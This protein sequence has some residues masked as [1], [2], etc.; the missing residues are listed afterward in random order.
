MHLL[1]GILA[2]LHFTVADQH[3]QNDFSTQYGMNTI[4][5]KKAFCDE[6]GYIDQFQWFNSSAFNEAEKT[7]P[8]IKNLVLQRQSDWNRD[9]LNFGEN[10]PF[11]ECSRNYTELKSTV[12][13]ATRSEANLAATVDNFCLWAMILYRNSGLQLRVDA[14]SIKMWHD[15]FKGQLSLLTES[16]KE[17]IKR[18]GYVSRLYWGSL[19]GEQES[20]ATD[21]DYTKVRGHAQ[22]KDPFGAVVQTDYDDRTA[23]LFNVYCEEVQLFEDFQ[24]FNKTTRR[25][26]EDLHRYICTRNP[27]CAYH[28]YFPNPQ[29]WE[30]F[31]KMQTN[32]VITANP[33]TVW[34][35]KTNDFCRLALNS[36]KNGQLLQHDKEAQTLHEEFK[37]ASDLTNSDMAQINKCGKPFSLSVEPMKSPNRPAEVPEES[38]SHPQK[39]PEESGSYPQKFPEES[40][41][42]PQKFPKESGSYPQEFPQES[43]SHPQKFPEESSSHPPEFPQES[44]SHPH[45]FP[46]RSDST[47]NNEEMTTTSEVKSDIHQRFFGTTPNYNS[48][49]ATTNATSNTTSNTT[50]PFDLN[51][52]LTYWD[53]SNPVIIA[54]CVAVGCLFHT[55]VVLAIA[56]CVCSKKLKERE[57]RE[58]E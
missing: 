8:S 24:W 39:F 10:V 44:G 51:T 52:F 45:E 13:V 19:T 15:Y 56:L 2:L 7:L 32:A 48:T 18:C 40:G 54:L 23:R 5:L 11:D 14:N 53:F 38:G 20:S 41:S 4:Q 57:E 43:G 26:V 37:K 29:C 30:T 28:Q 49:I 47:G 16:D 21:V 33:E 55:T 22:Y 42:Y 25:L 58:E 9:A 34:T 6:V 17:R 31:Q 1:F 36:A 46:G 12:P 50:M 27:Y 3:S 35:K